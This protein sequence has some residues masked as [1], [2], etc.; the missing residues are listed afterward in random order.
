MK[1]PTVADLA[2]HAGVSIATVNRLLHG[3][4]TVKPST[5]ERIIEAANEI[6]FYG[7][8][9][10]KSR[11]KDHLPSVRFGFL[12]QQKH[13]PIYQLWAQ[14]VVDASLSSLSANIEPRVRFEENLAPDV[15]AASL[16]ALAKEVDAV[17]VITADHPLISQAIDELRTQGIPVIAYI[18]DLSAANRAGFVGT[19][20]WK[21]GRTAAWFLTQLTAFKGNICPLIGSHRYQ[22]QDIADA[23]FRSYAREHAPESTVHETLL[24]H[25]I[26]EN[27][28]T[29]VK[30]LLKQDHNLTGLYV[31][32][33]GISGVLQARSEL[34]KRRQQELKII[35]R[36]LGPQTRRGIAEG[37]I[38][39]AFPHPVQRISEELI[40]VMLTLVQGH[41]PIG[42]QQR[43]VP[44]EVITPESIWN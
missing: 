9:T 38:M 26:P 35:C 18:S 42:I 36:D 5:V 15:I 14:G 34:S 25:E 17:A 31:N 16:K 27:A 22:C 29:Q 12:M 39:A 43:L 8:Q 21:A 44:F 4:A 7:L 20:N 30:R 24:T 1:R 11:K 32:G 41:N 10:L 6:G 3:S 37:H 28:Y 23:S 40:D 2:H 19:D 33:G 13:R